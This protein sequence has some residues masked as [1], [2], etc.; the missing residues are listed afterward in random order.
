[1]AFK[2]KTISIDWRATSPSDHDADTGILKGQLDTV[3]TYI[4]ANRLYSWDIED[5]FLIGV[6]NTGQAGTTQFK[7]FLHGGPGT[8]AALNTKVDAWIAT[9]NSPA[10]LQDMKVSENMVLYLYEPN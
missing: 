10:Q 7:A 4:L 9:L 3:N 6:V 1:M 8:F 5:E 2:Q